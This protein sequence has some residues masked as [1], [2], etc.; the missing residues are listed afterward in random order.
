MQLRIDTKRRGIGATVKV[1]LNFGH[2]V[3]SPQ[4]ILLGT[5]QIE[6][7]KNYNSFGAILLSKLP[8]VVLASRGEQGTNFEFKAGKYWLILKRIASRVLSADS[9]DYTDVWLV[10]PKHSPICAV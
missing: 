10:E 5:Q 2:R 4:K 9:A 6:A 8:A 1:L 7:I 3:L